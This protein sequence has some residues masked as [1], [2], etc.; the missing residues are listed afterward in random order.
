MELLRNAIAG[1]SESFQNIVTEWLSFVQEHFA[2]NA[3]GFLRAEAWDGIPRNLIRLTSGDLAA[4]DL[5]FGRLK[6]FTIEELCGRGLFNWFCDHARWSMNL[7]PE[8]KTIRSKMVHV[9]AAVIRTIEPAKLI[10]S[11]VASERRFQLWVNPGL[12][13]ELDA[14][15]DA[16]IINADAQG[17]VIHKLR[18]KEEELVRLREHADRLQLFSDTVRRTVPYRIYRKFVQPLLAVWHGNR[19]DGSP[20]K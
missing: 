3:A 2:S 13:V 6:P 9:L 8:A 1:R 7:Y 17:D 4:F 14:A 5:E 10:D 20:I 15:L 16:K 12:S 19:Q 11:V 18:T